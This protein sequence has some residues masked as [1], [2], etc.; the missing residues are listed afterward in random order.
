MVIEEKTLIGI[1]IVVKIISLEEMIHQ[2]SILMILG[3]NQEGTNNKTLRIGMI[4]QDTAFERMRG[5]GG[6]IIVKALG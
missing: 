5:T 4:T 1:I 3:E 6:K 2:N